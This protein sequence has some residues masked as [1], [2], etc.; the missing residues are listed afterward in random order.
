MNE[1]TRLHVVFGSGGSKAILGGAG[2]ILAFEI[3]GLREWLSIG[4]CSGGSLPAVFLASGKPA[5]TILRDVVDPD[6]GALLKPKTTFI[7]RLLAIL[8]K[9]KNEVRRPERGVYS[10]LPMSDYV[11]RTIGEW[12][13]S[14]WAVSSGKKGT[15]VLMK[16]RVLMERSLGARAATVDAFDHLPPLSLGTAVNATCAVPGF[17]D[18]VRF[19]GD[20]LHDGALSHYGECPA[21]VPV[22]YFGAQPQ[23]VLAFD[24]EPEQLKKQGWLQLAWKAACMGQC[25]PFDA[26]HVRA[27]DGYLVIRP[28]ITGFHGL[29][30]SLSRDLKWQAICTGFDTTAATLLANNLVLDPARRQALA[31]LSSQFC[32]IR[33]SKA[34]ASFGS[35]IESLL[36]RRELLAPRRSKQ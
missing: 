5:R 26:N 8:F 29:Q 30:F 20:L 19:N 21:A 11:R 12:P 14:F 2:A 28:N 36:M 16:D 17:I 33:S 9:Y 23:Q 35:E 34:R 22:R 6:F 4:S 25:A 31:E 3:A 15:Y 1:E 32:K 24:I 7:G 18:A 10:A 27:A 13:K